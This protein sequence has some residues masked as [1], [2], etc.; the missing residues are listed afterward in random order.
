[1]PTGE[2]NL[3]GLHEYDYKDKFFDGSPILSQV[4]PTRHAS[5]S[6]WRSD[7]SHS[8]TYSALPCRLC[9]QT[10]FASVCSRTV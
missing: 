6:A 9:G 7:P 1:M 4:H 8:M 5:C 2:A 10:A 3:F